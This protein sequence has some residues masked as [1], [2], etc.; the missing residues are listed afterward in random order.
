[1]LFNHQSHTRMCSASSV[2]GF[3]KSFPIR[4]PVPKACAEKSVG[5]LLQNGAACQPESN[6][7]KYVCSRASELSFS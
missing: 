3:L 7:T 2:A 1:M 5:V 6:P 4:L